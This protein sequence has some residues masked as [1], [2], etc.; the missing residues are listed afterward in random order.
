VDLSRLDLGPER[1][2]RSIVR[3]IADGVLDARLA[4][5]LWL[6]LEARLPVVVAAG[7]S[8]T[9]KTVL[10]RALLAFLPPSTRVRTIAGAW[11]SWGWLPADVRAEL[12]VVA[13]GATEGS[14]V[15]VSSP[16]E[17]GS[18]FLVVPELSMHLPI[19][20][21]NGV[22]RTAIRLATMGY[23]LGATIHAESLGGV[24]DE[25]RG[26]G[27]GASSDELSALGVVVVLR[28]VD[29]TLEPSGRRRVV[30]AHYVRPVAR[31]AEGHVQRLPPAVL[32]TWAAVDDTFED[33]SWGVTAEL[34]ARVGRKAGDLDVERDRRAEWLAA[35]VAGGVDGEEDAA[36]AI[37]SYVA[38]P[39]A[40]A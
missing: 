38:R 6:L 1:D 20:A 12:G 33:F 26:P 34:A 22:A 25:L 21:W 31:D 36:A 16:L 10:L 23:G 35:L 2:R 27:V 13:F 4:A 11:E 37:R 40:R 8:G 18:A 5:L 7:P 39:A 3:L 24:L 29:G 17:P 14:G 30:A 15:D 9:G 32:A 28:A 19:Y